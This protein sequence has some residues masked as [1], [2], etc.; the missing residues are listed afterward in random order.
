VERKFKFLKHEKNGY[1]KTDKQYIKISS[2]SSI[3]VG[4]S[5]N[6]ILIQKETER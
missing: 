3:Y 1:N 2:I 6:K 5:I 4:T